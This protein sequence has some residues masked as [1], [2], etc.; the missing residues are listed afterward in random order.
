MRGGTAPYLYALLLGA[1]TVATSRGAPSG[2]GQHHARGILL[3]SVCQWLILGASYLGRPVVGPVLI[4][5]PYGPSR[6]PS[7]TARRRP[8]Q[9]PCPLAQCCRALL[10][11]AQEGGDAR[12]R[13]RPRRRCGGSRDR[14]REPEEADPRRRLPPARREGKAHVT[15]REVV[16]AEEHPAPPGLELL[17]SAERGDTG[18]DRHRGF[19]RAARYP[20]MSVTCRPCTDSR[21]SWRCGRPRGS[22]RRSSATGSS[23]QGEVAAGRRKT[24]TADVTA[25]HW[26][27][28]ARRSA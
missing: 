26:S 12:G 25:P 20:G 6:A 2:R 3:D 9:A 8:R 13:R 27:G 5:L 11:R 1:R 16:G 28:P 10:S 14:R 21:A 19:D 7:P 15:A 23:P 17:L 24:S 18:V 4:A 22:R